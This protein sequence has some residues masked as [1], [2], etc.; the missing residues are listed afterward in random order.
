MPAEGFLALAIF[1]AGRALYPAYAGPGALSDQR[2]A[3]ALLWIVGDL[4]MLGALILAAVAW[5]ADE[6][7]RQRRIEQGHDLRPTPAPQ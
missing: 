6:E 1:S 3:A 7:A 4:V 5:K 2:S